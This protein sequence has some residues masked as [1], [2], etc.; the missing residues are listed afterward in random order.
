MNCCQRVLSNS[1]CAAAASVAK[2]KAKAKANA[3]LK[4]KPD[5]MRRDEGQRP[6]HSH[7]ARIN[8]NQSDISLD[9][10]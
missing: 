8:S 3:R 4:S 5:P 7:P 2:A 10:T 6:V 1:T 9:L